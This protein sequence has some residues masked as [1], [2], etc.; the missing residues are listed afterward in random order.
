MVIVG[1][2]VV[3]LGCFKLSMDLC[4]IFTSIST[5]FAYGVLIL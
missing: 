2:R 4:W 5:V 1:D 3:L